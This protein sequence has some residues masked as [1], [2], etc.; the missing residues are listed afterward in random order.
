MGPDDGETICFDFGEGTKL[1]RGSR[2]MVSNFVASTP[3]VENH[4][5]DL[6]PMTP[7]GGEQGCSLGTLGN[8]LGWGWGGGG[9]GGVCLGVG[10][11]EER[12]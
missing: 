6:N 9:G 4:A 8:S 7:V 11:S 3:R 12:F 2:S 1:I 5:A 10:A